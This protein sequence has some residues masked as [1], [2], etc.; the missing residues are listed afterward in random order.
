MIDFS[1]SIDV[2][3]FD[4]GAEMPLGMAEEIIHNWAVIKNR[5]IIK[6]IDSGAWG[7]AFLLDDRQVVKVT[8]SMEEA[9]FAYDAMHEAPEGYV[10]IHS[11]EMINESVFIILMD[12][13][14]IP[15]DFL[16][17]AT[18]LDSILDRQFFVYHSDPIHEVEHL[19]VHD[20]MAQ[21]FLDIHAIVNE[22]PKF[23]MAD[24]HAGNI[25]L[26]FDSG[27]VVIFDQ[28]HDENL[29]NIKI[30]TFFNLIDKIDIKILDSTKKVG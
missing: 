30:S 23:K 20:E 10:P 15:K 21:L 24:I 17:L 28:L 7:H 27:E 8:I 22:N 5:K 19:I 2:P 4:E 9:V 12:Y 29:S 6:Y 11:V 26:D 16:E 1:N 18:E 14:N 3:F 13:L 25:G